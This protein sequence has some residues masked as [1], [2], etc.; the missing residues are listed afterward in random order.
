MPDPRKILVIQTASIGDVILATPLVESLALSYPQARIDFLLKKGTESL[1]ENHPLIQKI[2][3]WDKKKSK[4][5]NLFRIMRSVRKEKFDMVIN[6][7]R[8]FSS[9]LITACSNAGIR[10]GFDKNPLSFLFTH[11]SR[12]NIGQKDI[13]EIDR[14]L[15][16]ISGIV[17]KTQRIVRLYPSKGDF[18]KMDRYKGSPYICIAPASLWYTKQYPEERWVELISGINAVD[19]IYLIGSKSDHELCERII[20]K[21]DR[22]AIYNLAGDLSFLESAALMKNARMNFVND[23][24]PMHLASAVNAP[25]TTIFCSTV[26]DFGF[27]PL[28]V[29]SAVV[30]THENLPCRPCGLHGYNKCPEKHF[31]C[32][33]TIDNHELLKR[34]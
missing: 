17:G 30:E 21:S 15:S 4:T 12:H 13:H 27:G 2:W 19:V 8:F 11:R 20:H 22:G 32:A 10:S 28:S 26:T 18:I 14:N 6:A 16:L 3:I 24:A 34:S 33:T 25:V 29:D 23:S 5:R 7:Q 31:K 1:M 9:G